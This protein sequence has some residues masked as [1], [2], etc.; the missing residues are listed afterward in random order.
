MEGKILHT[1]SRMTAGREAAPS[2]LGATAWLAAL[3]LLAAPPAFSQTES[4]AGSEPLTAVEEDVEEVIV[5]G[6]RIRRSGFNAPTPLTMMS[7]E[8]IENLGQTNVSETLKLIPQ[9]S[10]FKSDASAGITAGGDVGASYANLRGLNPFFGTRTLTLVNTRRFIPTSDG[11]AVDLNVIPSILIDRVETVTGGASAAYGT[12]AIAGVVNILL[13]TDLEG[14]KFQADYGQTSRGDGDT[15]HTAVAWGTSLSQGR[16]HFMA[17]L[18][19]QNQKG[20]GNC[21]EVR[22]WCAESW[23]VYTNASNVMPDGSLSGY[24]IP[25]SQG[26]GMPNFVMGPGGRQ[27]FND[28]RGV[29]RNRAPAAA[30]ARNYRFTEDGSGIVEFDPGRYVSTSTFGP[31]QGGDGES[32][33]ADS[34]IQT[35]IERTVGYAYGEYALTDSLNFISELTYASREA[36]NSGVTAG[37]RS[38]FF[39]KP[40]NPYLPAELVTLLDGTS[41]SLGKDM[42]YQVPSTNQAEADVLRV[43]L[44]LNGDLAGSWTWDAYYQYGSNKRKQHRNN[45]RVNTSFVYALDAVVDPATDE[46]VCAETLAD[47]PDPISEGCVPLNLFGTDNLDPA[48][49]AYAYRPVIEDFDYS[50]QV[51]AASATGELFQGFGAGPIGAAAGLEYRFEDGDISHGD[52]PNY[53]DYAFTFGLDYAGEIKVLEAF[54]ELNVPLLQGKPFAEFLEFNGAIR[55]TRNESKDKLSGEQKKV[56]AT[57]WKLSG[58]Y[59]TFSWLRFRGSKSQD[60][61]AAGFRELYLKQVPTEE[62]S[63]QGIVDNPNIPGSPGGGG[64]DPTPILSGGSFSLKPESADTTT[65]GVILSPS[66]VPGLRLSVDSYE[67]KISDSVTT[68]TG[69]RIV[70]YCDG[71]NLFCDRITFASDTDITFIDARQVNL[72]KLTV[73]GLD[74]EVDYT[75]Q[76]SDLSDSLSGLLNL[77]LLG[78][79]Q[80]S[81][82]VQPE[83]TV[84][85]TDYAG[86]SGPVGDGGDFN[87]APDWIWTGFLTYDTGSFNTTVSVRYIGSGIYDV[88]KTGPQ[89]AGYD[90][91]LPDS[92]SNNRVESA[93]YVSLAMSY[94]IPYGKSSDGVVEVFGSLENIFDTKPPVA[95]GGGGLGGSNYPTNPTYFDTFG[96]RFR[97]GVR[98]RF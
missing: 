79:H 47:D 78:N 18:E 46:I 77:R 97:A 1:N 30:A 74:V 22:L 25:G 85:A 2:R 11:G 83:P 14:F 66:F 6:S 68:L 92:I 3:G 91:T 89:D 40:T 16:G 52:I 35:P 42:D 8:V 19:H 98:V 9:N 95:P 55:Q 31:R 60:I 75:L 57:S 7:A 86:Q 15:F 63:S 84:P 70:D 81:L 45:S 90:P 94:E 80:Y 32:T 50:Q 34:D 4:A 29:V 88:E 10:S 27:A 49:V 87:P 58:V 12:D 44:G 64:D 56:T 73:R 76:L 38:T 51:L 23:D 65:F 96:S 26:Y 5:T 36:S 61:R 39:V 69:Q 72:G 62:G 43:V 67:I 54:G 21:A 82:L 53:N 33:Y 37:P 93:T 48:A 59:D 20:I 28:R 71:F 41:F 24:D 17:G 13:D